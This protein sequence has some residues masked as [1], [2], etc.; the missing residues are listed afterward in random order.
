MIKALPGSWPTKTQQILLLLELLDCQKTMRRRS[1][2]NQISVLA[3]T[4]TRH[5]QARCKYLDLLCDD[6][7][8]ALTQE[9]LGVGLRRLTHVQAHGLACPWTDL[10]H[11]GVVVGRQVAL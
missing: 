9:L 8:R 10:S 11:G 1:T 2:W 7:R 6:V 3:L 4:C 5:H